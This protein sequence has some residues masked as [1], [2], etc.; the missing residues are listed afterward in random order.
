LPLDRLRALHPRRRQGRAGARRALVVGKRPGAR[1]RPPCRRQWP[2]GEERGMSTLRTLKTTPP[3]IA[4]LAT[5]PL[6]HKLWRRKADIVGASQGALWK[7][8]LLEAAGAEVLVLRDGWMAADLDGAAIAVADIAD[9][10]EAARFI[11]TAHAAGAVVNIID[12]TELCDV[13]FG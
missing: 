4:P 3:R 11:A 9:D 7:A 13:T 6:F 2:A 10:A 1:M 8:E 5:L 12:R